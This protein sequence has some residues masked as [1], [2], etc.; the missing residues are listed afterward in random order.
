M[1][2]LVLLWPSGKTTTV[3]VKKADTS[4]ADKQRKEEV[5]A[6]L[7]AGE[8]LFNAGK[9]MTPADQPDADSA[10]AKFNEA[11]ALDPG[12][13]QALQWLKRIDEERDKQRRAREEAEKQRLAEEQARSVKSPSQSAPMHWRSTSRR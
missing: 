3:V 8:V 11:L 13:Q 6:L 4:A 5:T 10:F 7:Q 1:L 12:N 2:A 9:L